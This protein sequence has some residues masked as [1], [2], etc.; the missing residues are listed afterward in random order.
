VVSLA[1]RLVPRATVLAG[2]GSLALVL[3]GLSLLQ[4]TPY[5][6]PSVAATSRGMVV[7]WLASGDGRVPLRAVA[8]DA[9]LRPIG[10]V[11]TIG[12]AWSSAEIRLEPGPDSIL[13]VRLRGE[14]GIPPWRSIATL[15]QEGRILTTPEE[16]TLRAPPTPP[17]PTCTSAPSRLAA[18]RDRRD[19]VRAR[20][21]VDPGGWIRF[22]PAEAG[23]LAPAL[24]LGPASC[25][26]LAPGPCATAAADRRGIVLA[27]ARGRALESELVVTRAPWR[28][29]AVVS[30]RVIAHSPNVALSAAFIGFLGLL[31][32]LAAHAARA[33][34]DA[35][36]VLAA[37]RLRPGRVWRE[38]RVVSV[39]G[40]CPPTPPSG[41][42]R[43]S[44]FPSARSAQPT[45][46]LRG[47]ELVAFEGGE[48]WRMRTAA[49]RLET[50]DGRRVDL[51]PGAPL[52]VTEG[53]LRG[54]LPSLAAATA[55]FDRVW[56]AGR[57]RDAAELGPY[58]VGCGATLEAEVVSDRPLPVVRRAARA[59][60]AWA[61]W[62][63][64]VLAGGFVVALAAVL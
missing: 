59:T 28:G 6:A 36:R 53:A 45:S 31:A 50:R 1:R 43:G 25:P 27:W 2:L 60:L 58:R 63:F 32:G 33:A 3:H 4:P 42:P 12:W 16:A 24:R 62:D 41:S 5:G 37:I 15:D 44:E 39:G 51:A 55:S 64:A 26:P 34:L 13:R 7:A 49:A 40:L 19:R 52:V 21:A 10:P 46:P 22:A 11:R 18:V 47:L 29:R 57:L 8:L 17:P 20:L 23:G 61:L 38:G 35:A 54:E 30:E 14:P 9:G 56:A 48:G